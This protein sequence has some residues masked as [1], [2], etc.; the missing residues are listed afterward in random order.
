MLLELVLALAASSSPSLPIQ[1][2]APMERARLVKLLDA[3]D[4][5]AIVA[6]FRAHPGATLPFVDSFLEGGLARLEKQGEAGREAMT[7]SFKTGVRFAA[8]ADEAFGT[9][10]FHSYAT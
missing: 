9:K 10:A 7:S 3:N 6:T 1:D 4:T 2:S 5:Q 8:L